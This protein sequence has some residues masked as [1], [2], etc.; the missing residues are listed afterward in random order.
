MPS[1]VRDLPPFTPTS[2]GSTTTIGI[3]HLDD[4]SSITLYYSTGAASTGVLSVQVSM[5]DPSDPF[6]QVGVT[7][8]SAF[9]PLNTSST[10]VAQTVLTTQ[11]SAIQIPNISFRGIKIAGLTSETAGTTVVFGTKQVNV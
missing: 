9:F 8:S 10:T 2:S 5:F 1:Q 3:G 6:P 11:G 4:A 7:Q